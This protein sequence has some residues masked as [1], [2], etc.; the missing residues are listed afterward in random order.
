MGL[1][2]QLVLSTLIDYLGLFDMPINKLKKEKILSLS[3][4]ILGLIFMIIL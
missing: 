2:G 1:F 4:I 3:I